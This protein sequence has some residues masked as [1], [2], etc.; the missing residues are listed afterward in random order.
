MNNNTS[1]NMANARVNKKDEFYTKFDTIE[2]E[3]SN[4]KKHFEGKTVYLNCDDPRESQFFNYFVQEFHNL[5]LKRLIASCYVS[6]DYNLFT[7]AEER[8]KAVYVDYDGIGSPQIQEL[9]GDGDFRSAESVS[10]L[11]QSDIVVTNPPFSLFR[12]YIAQLVEYDKKYL[13][14]GNMNAITY[15]DFFEL[16]RTN[17]A[18]AGYSFNKA[19]EFKLPKG[20]NK[21]DRIDEKTGDK[22]AVVPAI[23]WW[24]N[25]EHDKRKSFIKLS[26][27]K[28]EADFNKYLTF[29]AINIDRVDDIP[30]GYKGIMGVPITFIGRY[31]PNQFELLGLG[32]GNMLKELGG[33]TISQEFLDEYLAQGGTG[34]YVANQ[35]ILAY[36]DSEGN[37]VIPYMRVLIKSKM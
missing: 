14:I 5:K 23:S 2:D 9:E 12:E 20:Y 36:Y 30:S 19:I 32:A 1:R 37:P 26:E 7:L 18:W 16:I 25:I 22:Y 11:K 10:F 35:H 8:E 21:Y 6:Q 4:Y 24:T 17:K 31:N 3:V 28:S 29:D 34:N 13:I 27:N 33:T 15:K